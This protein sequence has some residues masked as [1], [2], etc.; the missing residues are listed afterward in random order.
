MGTTWQWCILK[1]L[2][3][4]FCVSHVSSEGEK[5]HFPYKTDFIFPVGPLRCQRTDG[6]L[7]FCFRSAS[8]LPL[9]RCQGRRHITDWCVCHGLVMSLLC[10]QRFSNAKLSSS[11]ARGVWFP[12]SMRMSSWYRSC[13][14]VPLSQAVVNT[15]APQRSVANSALASSWFLLLKVKIFLRATGDLHMLQSKR[16]IAAISH[17]RIICTLVC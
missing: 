3:C 10:L 13:W 6:F 14:P 9:I 12:L 11:V 17:I 8:L 4:I 2:V 7:Y 15:C 16:L 5:K 1:N